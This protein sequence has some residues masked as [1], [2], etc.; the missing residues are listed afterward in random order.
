MASEMTSGSQ[1]RLPTQAA[2]VDR[3]PAPAALSGGSGMEASAW[4]DAIPG[5]LTGLGGLGI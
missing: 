4:Y 1:L 2:P 3:M 5:I